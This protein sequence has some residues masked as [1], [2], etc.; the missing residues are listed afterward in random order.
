MH[1]L[2][3]I[4]VTL[5][6]AMI[7]MVG[8]FFVDF[9]GHAPQAWKIAVEF[10]WVPA[11]L[12]VTPVIT[13]LFIISLLFGRLFCSAICPLGIFQDIIVR[14]SRKM[15]HRKKVKYEYSNPHNYIRYGI[16][17]ATLFSFFAG[18]A[19]LLLLLDPYSNFGRMMAALFRP[20]AIAINNGILKLCLLLGFYPT[21]IYPAEITGLTALSFGNGITVLILLLLFTWRRGRLYCNTICPV[22]SFLGL[23]AHVSLFRIKLDKVQCT[24][25]GICGTICKSECI[26]AKKQT[27]DVSRCVSCFNCLKVCRKG[28]IKYKFVIPSSLKRTSPA[29]F[30]ESRRKALLFTTT[31]AGSLISHKVRALNPAKTTDPAASRKVILPPGADFLDRFNKHCTACQ[32]CVSKCPSHVLQPATLQYGI[33]GVL[34]PQ[35]VYKQG[36]CNYNCTVCMDVCPTNALQPLTLADKRLTQVGVAQF[37]RELCIVQSEHTDCGACAEHCPTQAVKMV[38]FE[39]GLTIPSLD[40]SICIGCGGCE[41]ICP[42][43]PYQ[44]IYIEGNEFH[45]RVLPPAESEQFKKEIDDFGF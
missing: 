18:S 31:L 20:L 17:L 22:G 2:K 24:G 43:R 35:M 16:L 12:A 15:P 30:C 32:L 10:Q 13:F 41:F 7:A 45:H 19:G 3:I 40:P 8:V 27:V 39:N 34:Q 37:R 21:S 44:A 23:L 6:L 26:D 42:V 38:P 1:F 28:A 14:I 4:R 5:A 36:Y 9:T 25:C 11:I 33:E 29:Y